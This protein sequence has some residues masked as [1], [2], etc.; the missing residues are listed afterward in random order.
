MPLQPLSEAGEHYYII[1]RPIFILS[2]TPSLQ[3]T[4]AIVELR[5][6][7]GN[8]WYMMMA[9]SKARNAAEINFQF[10]IVGSIDRTVSSVLPAPDLSSTTGITSSASTSSCGVLPAPFAFIIYQKKGGAL[11]G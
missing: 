11:R 9:A 8:S 2:R 10:S 6:Q 1:H 3:I 7:I 5:R 4:L